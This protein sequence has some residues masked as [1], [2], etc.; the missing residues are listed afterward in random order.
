MIKKDSS[1]NE[2]PGKESIK[3]NQRFENNMELKAPKG[4][5]DFLPQEMIKRQ[6]VIDTIRRVY[7]RYGFEPLETP[8]F[9]NWDVLKAKSG[10]EAKNQIYYFKDKSDR[11]LGLRFDQTVGTARV[12]AE[13]PDLPKPIKRYTIGKA[14]RYEEISKGRY[15]EFTQAD[16]DIIGI[17]EVTADAEC[18]ACIAE[19]LKE[20]GIKKI[21]IR[22][23][24]RKVL[25]AFIKNIGLEAKYEDILRIVD[26]LDK[27]GEQEVDKELSKLTS[28][29]N[30]EKIM[31]FTRGKFKLE[32]ADEAIEELK[33]ILKL[34]EKMNISAKA[35]IDYSMVRGLGYYSGAI[36]EIVSEDYPKTIAAG[37]RYDNLIAI[38]GTD[39]PATGI[40]IGVDR[41]VEILDELKLFEKFKVGKTSVACFVAAVNKDVFERALE[42]AQAIRKAKINCSIDLQQRS[43]SKNF[44]YCNSKGIPKIVIVGPKDLAEDKVTVR[45]MITGKESKVEIKNIAGALK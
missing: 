19:A 42:I 34:L 32:E 1:C 36:V 12:A 18:I 8:A 7:E 3:D 28:T 15:R 22:L 6:F 44:E 43:L 41:I 17:K 24:S 37:G 35:E 16:I 13:N 21:K 10:E 23:N 11:E 4:T 39:L 27:I 14:W 38:Y 20:L 45:D 5:R 30:V 9:E 33:E 26:K 29:E 40:S 25:N 31:K 2:N